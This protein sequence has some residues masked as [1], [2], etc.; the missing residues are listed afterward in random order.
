[1]YYYLSNYPSICATINVWSPWTVIAQ[2]VKTKPF[3]RLS[4]KT[5][6]GGLRT[7]LFAAFVRDFHQKKWMCIDL[8][9]VYDFPERLN[10]S[11]VTMPAAKK[12]RQNIQ[13]VAPATQKVLR[14]PRSKSE[15]LSSRHLIV[16]APKVL[17]SQKWL[18]HANDFAA[19]SKHHIFPDLPH[20]TTPPLLGA[21]LSTIPSTRLRKTQRLARFLTF[22][23][24]WS[25]SFL[26]S[27]HWLFPLLLLH[28]CVIRKL[29]FKTSFDYDREVN[30]VSSK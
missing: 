28:L 14:T 12:R 15:R 5:E 29:N 1:M 27:L 11:T 22:H 21:S 26:F 16:P 30:L 20:K 2:A 19:R 8:F 17:H 13:N 9:V 18:T 4:P 6:V 25:S 3:A 7:Q 24:L 23:I 10:I